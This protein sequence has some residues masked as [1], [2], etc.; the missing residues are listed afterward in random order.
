MASQTGYLFQSS[1]PYGNS[2][3]VDDSKSLAGTHTG[4]RDQYSPL[5]DFE[6]IQSFGSTVP[7]VSVRR[8]RVTHYSKHKQAWEPARSFEPLTAVSVTN[9]SFG[10]TQYVSK[11]AW[12]V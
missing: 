7:G 11:L 1:D 6:G 10:W 3:E 9:E 12:P 8:S 5:R 4:E 2:S